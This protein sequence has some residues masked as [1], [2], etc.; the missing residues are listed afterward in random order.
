MV[1]IWKLNAHFKYYFSL[2]SG[3]LKMVSSDLLPATPGVCGEITSLTLLKLCTW[4]GGSDFT[5]IMPH[6]SWAV[7]AANP[8]L[9][10]EAGLLIVCRSR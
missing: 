1:T 2:K 8:Q 10:A 9:C 5:K 6:G 4:Q 7:T 3:T